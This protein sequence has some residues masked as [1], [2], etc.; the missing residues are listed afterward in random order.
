MREVKYHMEVTHFYDQGFL[1]EY[2]FND[3]SAQ[4]AIRSYSVAAAERQLYLLGLYTFI[5]GVEYYESLADKCKEIV[6]SNNIDIMCQH[7]DGIHTKGE[8]LLG[9]FRSVHR[10]TNTSTNVLWSGHKILSGYSADGKEVYNTSNAVPGIAIM[11]L[12]RDDMTG[13]IPP[14]ATVLMHELSHTIGAK[15]HYHHVIEI[16]EDGEE[17]CKNAEICSTCGTLEKRD[18]N[19]LMSRATGEVS[20]AMYCDSCK[21]EILA[22]LESH[23][24]V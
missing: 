3:S 16:T 17:V 14:M 19:C 12:K 1:V 24:S 9:Y 4:A 22:H 13:D 11:L 7:E 21:E 2:N 5:R 10:G 6:T 8:S 20:S 18:I 23:H 15:D